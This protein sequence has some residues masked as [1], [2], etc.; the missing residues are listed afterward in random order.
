MQFPRP[1]IKFSSSGAFGE[2]TLY[3]TTSYRVRDIYGQFAGIYRYGSVGGSGGDLILNRPEIFSIYST[4]SVPGAQ[5]NTESQAIAE[6]D[7][8]VQI[9]LQKY[10]NPV[11]SEITY[12]GLLSGSL[13]GNIAQITWEYSVNYLPRTVVYEGD[14]LDL[15]APSTAENRRILATDGLS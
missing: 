8:Y 5:S 11:S 7:Q 12:P 15:A 13:D 10:S 4:S 9:F 14:A 2:P 3:L 1:M 6:A